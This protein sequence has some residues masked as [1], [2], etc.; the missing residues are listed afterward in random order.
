MQGRGRSAPRPARPAPRALPHRPLGRKLHVAMRRV[1]AALLPVLLVLA[2][3]FLPA[4][5]PAPPRSGGSFGGRGGFRSSGGGF[6]R[7][8][9]SG[10]TGRS[11]GGGPNVIVTPGWGWGWGFSPFGGYGYGGCGPVGTVMLL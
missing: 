5:A 10:G 11:W 8:A 1:L 7:S 3:V 6:S 2:I 4:L 9:P